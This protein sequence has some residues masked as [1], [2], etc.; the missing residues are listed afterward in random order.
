M[1]PK[2]VQL[3]SF[4]E[5]QTRWLVAAGRRKDCIKKEPTASIPNEDMPSKI[6]RCDVV[7]FVF[8]RILYITMVAP[9]NERMQGTIGSSA[10]AFS[11]A[12]DSGDVPRTSR[13]SETSLVS[14]STSSI[15]AASV[16]MLYTKV[17]V[18]V[19]LSSYCSWNIESGSTIAPQT[20]NKT[21]KIEIVWSKITTTAHR[22]VLSEKKAAPITA[23]KRPSLRASQPIKA[24][25]TDPLPSNLK[26]CPSCRSSTQMQEKRHA[27]F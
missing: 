11:C 20:K 21:P 24:S 16:I 26:L 12:S 18:R 17:M 13:E 10:R 2:N 27:L 22:R 7:L 5:A 3:A 23:R 19:V 14:S 4:P 1:N 25:E 6:R 9:V 8:Q 15:I